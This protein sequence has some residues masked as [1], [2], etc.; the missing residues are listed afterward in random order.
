MVWILTVNNIL[1][2]P[3]PVHEQIV[4]PNWKQNILYNSLWSKTL[5]K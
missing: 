1:P 4:N 3:L 5:F 2:S